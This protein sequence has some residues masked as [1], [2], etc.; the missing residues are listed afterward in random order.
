MRYI[1]ITFF[2]VLCLNAKALEVTVSIEPQKFFVN[3][4]AKD[5]VKVN[6]M[7]KPGFSPATYEPKTS[8]MKKLSSS[9]IYFAIGVP[10][11]NAWLKRFE[12][13]NE[14]MLIVDTSKTIKKLP[15]AKHSHEEE[16]EEHEKHEE[17]H[18]EK[19]DDHDEHGKIEGLDP[20]VWLDPI[21][22][23]KQALIIYDELV[24]LDF[25]NKDFYKSNLNIFL[26]EIDILHEDLQKTLKDYKHKEFMV[27][28]P[29]WGYFA[30]RYDLEQIAVEKEGK[31]PKLKEIVE[32]VHEAKEHNIKVIF[33]SPQFSQ[34]SAHTISDSLD[35]HIVT[36]DPMEYFWSDN[37]KVVA[38]V[39]KESYE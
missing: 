22:V 29:S 31:E 14:T 32:L 17:E 5:K 3:K 9:K 8:Q 34:E 24:K 2:L 35:G 15:M 23:K 4:I 16:H 33:V 11:E 39:I 21:L 19:H 37:L 13:A 30:K 12:Y 10:F 7:V 28:H 1:I 18:K 38:N 36:I 6:V 25:K 27:F 26:K 20:H